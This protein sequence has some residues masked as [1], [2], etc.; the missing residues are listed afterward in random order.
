MFDRANRHTDRERE[1][2]REL[3]R[4]QFSTQPQREMNTNEFPLA[5]RR[6]VPFYLCRMS[7]Y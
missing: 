3:Y 2:E 6:G 7:K 4:N 5:E 1:R